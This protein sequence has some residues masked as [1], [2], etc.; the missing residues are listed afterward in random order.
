M[1]KRRCPIISVEFGY[2]GYFAYG[3]SPVELITFT[4]ELEDVD[5]YFGTSFWSPARSATGSS[6]EPFK[7]F[8][9]V[10]RLR[11]YRLWSSG[12]PSSAARRK[13]SR[14]ESSKITPREMVRGNPGGAGRR[15]IALLVP[16][17]EARRLVD[18]PAP[19]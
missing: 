14:G 2:P 8:I 6:N 18:R 15:E 17:K 4:K 9:A 7:A 13:Q 5:G 10:L 16:D 11:R 19:Q 12:R 1:I 3:R